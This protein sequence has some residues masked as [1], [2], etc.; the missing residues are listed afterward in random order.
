MTGPEASWRAALGEGRLLLQRL[1]G[2]RTV[3]PPRVAGGETGAAAP[4]WVEAAGTGR[5]YT[6]SWV[7][8]RP[9]EEPYNVAVIE[10]D[11]GPRLM[12]R[13]EAVSPETLAIGLRVRMR[14]DRAAGEPLLLFR[15]AEG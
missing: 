1:P 5:V 4:E 7:N 3:F 2:G 12:S 15:P 8:R 13:V 9:P 6:F 14:I 10:L 11:E